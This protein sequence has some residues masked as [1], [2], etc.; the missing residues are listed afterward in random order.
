MSIQ[1]SEVFDYKEIIESQAGPESCLTC[2]WTERGWATTAPAVCLS[3]GL[4]SV[5]GASPPAS[6]A[7]LQRGM[8]VSTAP[9]TGSVGLA[10]PE[11]SS[12][13]CDTQGL[14][15]PASPGCSRLVW[16]GVP[17]SPCL[18]TTGKL[19]SHH[20]NTPHGQAPQGTT[21]M[22]WDCHHILFSQW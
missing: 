22:L 6:L 2:S 8:E 10:G 4:L 19:G 1:V 21:G 15:V 18:P 9:I 12:R 14:A 20:T 13:H 7:R 5:S 17:L 3:S 11:I 16:S